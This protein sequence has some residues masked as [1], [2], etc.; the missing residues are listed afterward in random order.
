[1]IIIHDLC[2]LLPCLLTLCLN[3]RRCY[4]VYRIVVTSIEEDQQYCR[5]DVVQQEWNVLTNVHLSIVNNPHNI[6]RNRDI[7]D[8]IDARG[9]T[10]RNL[11]IIPPNMFPNTMVREL[12]WGEVIAQLWD[13][14][15]TILYW[16][17]VCTVWR[18]YHVCSALN[19]LTNAYTAY[20]NDCKEFQ[21][22]ARSY[23]TRSYG[24]YGIYQSQENKRSYEKYWRRIIWMQFLYLIRDMFILIPFSFVIFTL[25]RLPGLL[26]ELY[27]K[28]L[29][30]WRS[31]YDTS[32]SC[33]GECTSE[34]LFTITKATMEYNE[35]LNPK[36]KFSLMKVNN[37]TISTI[38]TDNCKLFVNANN[39]SVFWQSV[40]NVIVI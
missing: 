29:S 39:P 10:S 36:L 20:Y 22:A 9:S 2:L 26:I 23:R 32:N 27:S 12:L 21:R 1:M 28:C 33:S 17:I 31:L 24:V 3:G 6:H 13:I 5:A 8:G 40:G 38:K 19:K 11:G 25:Y 16:L 15:F 35:K 37:L 4:N 7:V 30:G 18:S 34:P 14:P